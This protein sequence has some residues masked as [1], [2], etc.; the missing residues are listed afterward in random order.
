MSKFYKKVLLPIQV[1]T[2]DY[3]WDGNRICGYFDNEGGHGRCDLDIGVL[4]RDKEGF[5]PKPKKC[6]ELENENESIS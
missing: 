6:L 4:D 3:C 5:Y 2:G 1:C